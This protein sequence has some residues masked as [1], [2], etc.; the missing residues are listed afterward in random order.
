MNAGD[1]LSMNWDSCV[2]EIYFVE[3]YWQEDN[4]TFAEAKHKKSV[5]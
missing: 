2:N 5:I 3:F 4:G 1:S